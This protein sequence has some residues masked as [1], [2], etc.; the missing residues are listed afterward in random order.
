VVTILALA[1]AALYGSAD[2][3]GGAASRRASA[4][5]VLAI[6][7]PAG[8]AV[9]VA[10]GLVTGG[11]SAMG[12]AGAGGAAAAGATGSLG[13]IAFY[14]GFA[15][16]PMSVVAPVSALI[17]TVL[18]VGVAVAQGERPG[19]GVA[20]GAIICIAAVILVSVGQAPP[21]GDRPGAPHPGLR[22]LL[23]AVPAG[24]AFGLFFLFMKNAGTSGVIWPVA[25][26]RLAGAAVAVACCVVTRTRPLGWGGGPGTRPLLGIALASGAMDAAANVCYVLATRVGMFGL[27]VVITSLYPGTTVLL[28]RV[29]FGERMRWLQR[30][31]LVLAAAGVIMVTV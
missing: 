11:W 5:A 24:L 10:A 15:A 18:P 19:L 17:S 4:L 28:A 29:V 30:A 1:A 8:C 21:D 6:T 2:F 20:I 23:Y 7:A 13:L 27:A 16:A 22:A 31:G 14:A 9:I 26:A 12:P 25:V 3:L